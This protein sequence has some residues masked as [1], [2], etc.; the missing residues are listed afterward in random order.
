M[1]N[2]VY[3]TVSN[4]VAYAQNCGRKRLKRKMQLLLADGPLELV[5]IDILV[6]L[7]RTLNR[8]QH[9]IVMTERYVKLTRAIPAKKK[10]RIT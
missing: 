5:A 1:A 9:V 6:S 2:E 4:C 8:N 7:P 10:S 3:N